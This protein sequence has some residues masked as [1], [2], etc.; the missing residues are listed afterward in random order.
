MRVSNYID[1]DKQRNAHPVGMSGSRRAGSDLCRYDP[2]LEL[3][4]LIGVLIV[5]KDLRTKTI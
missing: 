4:R 1:F 2:G 5:H 3:V